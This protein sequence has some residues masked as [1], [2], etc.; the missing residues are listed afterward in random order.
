MAYSGWMS[1][2]SEIDPRF[3]RPKMPRRRKSVRFEVF[4]KHFVA[5][6][7]MLRQMKLILGVRAPNR[8]LFCCTQGLKSLGTPWNPSHLA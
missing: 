6:P 2:L 7:R 1:S 3:D 8:P 4:P 5:R